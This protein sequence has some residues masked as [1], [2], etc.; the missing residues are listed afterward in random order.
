MNRFTWTGAAILVVLQ[1]FCARQCAYATLIASDDFESCDVDDIIGQGT[2]G[3]GWGGDWATNSQSSTHNVVS[4]VLSGLGQSL[5]V[6]GTNTRNNVVEREFDSQTGT[7]YIGFLIETSGL[8]GS[9]NDFFQL[10]VNDE[11]SESST[12]GSQGTSVS[13]GIDYEQIIDSTN[14][15]YFARKAGADE[16]PG[17]LA[18]TDEALHQMVF[19]ISKSGGNGGNYDEIALFVDQSSEGTP[20]IALGET[21]DDNLGSGTFTSL[22]YLHVR[23]SSLDSGDRVYLDNLRIATTFSEAIPEP[24]SGALAIVA[25]AFMGSLL[26]RRVRGGASA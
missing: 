26:V 11:S 12:S 2:S 16:V 15:A 10:Y 24:A 3:D 9:D 1:L 20:D 14:G 6:G 5:E 8:A 21:D 7:I 22:S 17:T 19:K 4:G 18:P 23:L 25:A 13:G